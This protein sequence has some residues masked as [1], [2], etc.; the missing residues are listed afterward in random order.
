MKLITA[1]LL[2]VCWAGSAFAQDYR[3]GEV[4][5][6]QG[7]QSGPGPEQRRTPDGQIVAPFK[8]QQPWQEPRVVKVRNAEGNGFSYGSGCVVKIGD[9]PS[10]ILTAAHTT[11]GMDDWILVIFN[12]G[13]GSDVA[14]V[15]GC[16]R[17][18][19]CAILKLAGGPRTHSFAIAQQE[20]A[21]GEQVYSA[22]FPNAKGVRVRATFAAAQEQKVRDQTGAWVSRRFYQIDGAAIEGESGGPLC[23]ENQEVIGVIH[24]NDTEPIL[25]QRGRQVGCKPPTC[26]YCADLGSIQAMLTQ[27]CPGGNCYGPQ[28][29]QPP[30]QWRPPQQT[31]PPAQ[32]PRQPAQPPRQPELPVSQPLTP[33]MPG[34]TGPQGP[35]GPEGP[36]GPPGV[37][38]DPSTACNCGPKW[39]E[40]NAAIAALRADID[41][42]AKA[43]GDLTLIV[44]ELSKRPPAPTL[45]EI[46]SEVEKRRKPPRVRIVDPAG[47]QTTEYITLHDNTDNDLLIEQKFTIPTPAQ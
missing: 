26:G 13:V 41:A 10:Y 30:P 35:P 33:P 24:S 22:G 28:Y 29:Y 1:L 40:I 17:A 7:W 12:D 15:I 45:D 34:P 20:P 18:A 6:Q 32:P 4:P 2:A 11:G 16:D 36:P 5:D 25:D 31:R 42:S 23:N 43:T 19:D 38:A 37:S 21:Q 3:I 46:L 39:V 47:D 8:P 27:C 44:N 14:Q 9:D